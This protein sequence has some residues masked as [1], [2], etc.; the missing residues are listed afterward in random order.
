MWFGAIADDVTGGTDLASVLRRHGAEV[1]QV[2]DIPDRV[3]DADAIVV[4]LKTRTAPAAQAIAAAKAAEAWLARAGAKQVFFKYCSTF[5]S[6]D[7]GNIGPVLDA[8]LDQ[9]SSAFTVACPAYPSMRRTV[10]WGHLFVGDQLLSESPMR[11]HPLTPMTDANLVRVLS[12]QS[13]STVGLVPLEEVEEGVTAVRA[14]F[15]RLAR[16]GCRVAIADAV[17]D[18]HIAILAEA[19]GDLRLVSGGAALGGALGGKRVRSVGRDH[20]SAAVAPVGPVAILSGSCS[21]ATLAQV[22]RLGDSLPTAV[23]NPVDLATNADRVHE[24]TAWCRPLARRGVDLAIVSSAPPED[25]EA[26]R[27]QL[28]R[29]LAADLVESAFRTVAA[30]LAGA[31]VRTFIVA[32]GETSGAVLQALGIRALRFG[33]EIEAGVPWVESV[34]PPG[35]SLALKSGNFGSPEFFLRALGEARARA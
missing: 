19:A 29:E 5:D 28:G 11:H 13:G 8:L 18:R 7:Q 1:V 10:Y 6:T 22:S 30:A 9:T 20:T 26:M 35:F 21:A 32:G 31:G 33:P 27:T 16:T 3:P 25:L 24:I 14:A 4:S 17:F 15:E 2:L 12:R 34:D 23:I